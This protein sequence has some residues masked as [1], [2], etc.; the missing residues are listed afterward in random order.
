MAKLA[1]YDYLIIG[2]GIAG[3]TA[4]ETIRANDREGSIAIISNEGDPLYSRVLLPSYLRRKLDREKVYLRTMEDYS[5]RG[6]DLALGEEVVGVNFDTRQVVTSR[7]K[8]ISFKKMLIATGGTPIPWHIPGSESSRVLRLQTIADADRARTVI[9][10]QASDPNRAAVVV[11]GGFIGLEF[12]ETAVAYG[13]PVHFFIREKKCFGDQFDDAGWDILASNFARRG[14]IVHPET[15]IQHIEEAG[16]LVRAA[17]GRGEA[18]AGNWIGLGIGVAK[19][20]GVFS[21]SGIDIRRGIRA[22]KF[23]QTSIP[24]VWTAGDVAEFYDV[25]LDEYRIV[26]NWTNAFLQGKAAGA[27]M[28]RADASHQTEFRAVSSYSITNLGLQLTQ[29][30]ATQPAESR[31][32][33]TRL[34]PAG[35]AYERLFLEKGVL[36]GALLINRFADKI[37][38]SKLIDRK[39]DLNGALERLRDVNFNVA[40]LL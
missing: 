6:I 37:P 20:F 38:L 24:G 30:G 12:I 10:E 21:G 23:L 18:V 4:A 5:R 40:E 29:L 27:N 9:G 32:T 36:K 35:T 14:V 28:S 39:T 1:Y 2:G 15:E 3:V 17:F 13:Y 7:E 11:G 26:G 22:D 8:G 25:T 16:G 31:E 34:W 33:V 19:N